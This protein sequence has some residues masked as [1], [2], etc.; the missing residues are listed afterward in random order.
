MNI[1]FSQAKNGQ[2]SCSIKNI[3]F[4]SSYNPEREAETFVNNIQTDFIPSCIII[5]EPGLSYISDYLRKRFP[6]TTLVAIRLINDFSE[7]DNKWDKVIY[8]RDYINFSEII[9]NTL[10]EELLLSSIQLNW[11]PAQNIFIDELSKIWTEIKKS[12]L[13]SR[14][15]LYTRSY[16]SQKWFLNS[17]SFFSNVKNIYSFNKINIPI[18]ITASGPS[19]QSSINKIKE[20]RDSFFLIG[21]SSS[22]SV[23]QKNEILPDLIMST[24]GGFWSKFHLYSPTTKIQNQ[25]YALTDENCTPK[26]I[27]QNEKIIPL[28]YKNSIGEK[29]FQSLN[30]NYFYA[31]RN[32]TVSGTAAELALALTSK[33][34][35]FCGLD[36]SPSK[37]FQHTQPNSLEYFSQNKDFRL[38]NKESRISKSRFNST[39]S[40]ELYQNWFK[41][42]SEQFHNRIYRLSDDF[43]YKNDLNYI[44][45]VNWDFFQK[46][47]KKQVTKQTNFFT[48]QK[49]SFIKINDTIID[50]ILTSKNIQQELFPLE[51]IML[52]RTQN[53]KEQD[54]INKKIEIKINEL[55]EKIRILTNND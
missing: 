29:L 52:K 16:F 18:L 37:S 14:D 28:C 51:S 5:L 30:I 12:I 6:K 54:I 4:H 22:I 20:N 2:K 55:K 26:K 38:K 27:M 34:I 48:K 49:T 21:L 17:I 32:G 39:G 41:T 45:N 47:E 13:K 44:K 46:T 31:Q 33:N 25:F 10:G 40:L 7:Y 8:Y 1:V 53:K 9:Y 11:P 3:N 24:D 35:Y 43:D 36:L 50:E 15:I 19:L 23:L 42:Y